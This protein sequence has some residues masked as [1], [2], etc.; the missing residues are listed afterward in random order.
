MLP[1]MSGRARSSRTTSGTCSRAR[2]TPS[3][4]CMAAS[5]SV[6]GRRDST[7]STRSRVVRLF[8]TRSTRKARA[9]TR[10]PLASRCR[11]APSSDDCGVSVTDC[12]TFGLV[13]RGPCAAA[14]VPGLRPRGCSSPLSS[15][16]FPGRCHLSTDAAVTADAATR[17]RPCRR[18][19]A[20]AGSRRAR[21]LR[22]CRYRAIPTPGDATGAGSGSSTTNVLPTSAT[23]S[24][25]SSPPMRSHRCCDSASPT[26]V[27]SMPVCSRPEAVEG[28]EHP[29]EIL[30]PD[31]RPVSATASAEPAPA[32]PPR[33]S[34]RRF[35]PVGCTSRR[36]TTG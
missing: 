24:T 32:I 23:D 2:S 15:S 28:H 14:S 29:V 33:T 17:R 12:G 19:R 3:P 22:R 13:R 11:C 27:P 7:R 1:V 9:R 26:P 36:W 16:A 18:P 4:P 30:D 35:R 34:R 31:A 10:R 5:T 21:P 6:P 20:T 8:S 25:V